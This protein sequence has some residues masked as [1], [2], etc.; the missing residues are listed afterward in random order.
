MPISA[1]LGRPPAG[2]LRTRH[3]LPDA[4]FPPTRFGA[5]PGPGGFPASW[6]LSPGVTGLPL[7]RGRW[8]PLSIEGNQGVVVGAVGDGAG[9]LSVTPAFGSGTITLIEEGSRIELLGAPIWEWH[10]VCRDEQIGY[11]LISLIKA[12]G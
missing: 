3:D 7:R 11:V 12:D 10:P 6:L 5:G 4:T 1:I 9:K 2:G 8:G